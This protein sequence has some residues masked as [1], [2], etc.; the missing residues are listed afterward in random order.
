MN[1]VIYSIYL[2]VT[3]N[4]SNNNHMEKRASFTNLTLTGIILFALTINATCQKQRSSGLDLNSLD[5]YIESARQD[6]D[7]PGMAIA[8]VKDNE[9]I[10][11]KGYGVRNTSTMEKVDENTL[12]G[13]ASNT[14]AMTA[15]ALAILVDEGKISWNDK[16]TKYLPWFE[17]YDPYVSDAMTVKDLLYH[18]TGL[19]TFSGD[20]L[21][22]GTTHNRKEVIRR[23]RF[24]KPSY[25]FRTSFGYSNIMFLTAGEIIPE[26]TG[27]SWDEF[28]RKRFFDPL[29]MK[30]TNTSITSFGDNKNVAMGHAE[31]NGEY[32]PIPYINWDNVGPCGSVNSNVKE[33]T[34]WIKL[35]LNRGTLNGNLFFS[36]ETN[37]E[38]WTLHTA[39]P[40]SDRSEELWPSIHFRGYGLGWAL[41]DY[42]G[43]KIINHGG[44]LDGQISRVVL[45]PE[46]NFGFVILTNSIN[47][48]PTYLMYQ[49]LD[50]VFGMASPDTNWSKTGLESKQ[51]SIEYSQRQQIQDEESRVKNTQPSLE[52][53]KYTGRYGGEMYGDAEVK[54][55][56]GQLA[57]YFIPT[58]IF[59]GDLTHWHFDTFAIKLR[60][61][62]LLPEGKVSFILGKNGSVEEMKIDI[63]NPDFYFTELEFKKKNDK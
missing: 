32:V 34:S 60:N 12:F 3:T 42:H 55:E 20:L 36:E 10:F 44:G 52:L 6:W 51:G 56:N 4:C 29:E 61:S 38:M 9:V 17:L 37:R 54:L 1:I 16:V 23:A 15:A 59:E 47:S 58:P 22:Y 45:V 25:G 49:I 62:P 21:W 28:L 13:I 46:E 18:R 57:I 53:E 27:E 43:R 11:Q 31:V 26:V 14:K 33:M 35:Q 50:Q 7:I 2:S 41:F 63:P 8:I 24:L 30:L 48:L 5:R 40:V 39:Q 19:K